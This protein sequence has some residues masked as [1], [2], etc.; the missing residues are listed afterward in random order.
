MPGQ[1]VVGPHDGDHG[2]DL[3]VP[4]LDIACRRTAVGQADI[5]LAAQHGLGLFLFALA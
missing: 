2:R 5:G 4:D 1:C 3:A